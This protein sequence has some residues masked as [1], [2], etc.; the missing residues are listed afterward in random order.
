MTP[1]PAPVVEMTGITVAFPGVL[2]LDDVDLRLF[3]GEVH[4]IMG[5]NGAGKSTLVKALTGAYQLDRGEIRIDGVVQ[6]L[7]T[8][9]ES[10][11]AGIA[12]VYQDSHL[13]PNLSVAENVMLG[14][15]T[16]RRFGINWTAT[17]RRAADMLGQ[18]GLDD[19]DP[20]VRLSMLPPAIQQLVAIARA[21]VGAP[22]VLVL[23]EPTSSLEAD[24]V[25]RLFAVVRRLRDRGVAIVFISH[26]LEQVYAISDRMTVLRNGR[27]EGEYLTKRL[28]R[29]DLI[30]KMIGKDIAG[31]Q[32]LGSQ[33]Q[34]HLHEPLGG[35]VYRA[36]SLARRGQM[37]PIDL[38]LHR[39]EIVGL[40]GLRGSGRTEL[41]YLMS[42]A[43]RADSGA[44]WIDGRRS[45]IAT[46]RAGLRHRV[47][48]SSEN[49]RVE[50]VIEDLSVRDNI[51]LALQALRGWAR[52]I[53][54]EERDGLVDSYIEGL[55]IRPAAPD[56]P[57]RY[58][59][60]GAQQK[61]LLARWLATRPR[62]LILDEPTRGVD[63]AAKLDIQRRVAQLAR[64]GVAV[65]FI[66]SELEEVVRLSDRI[67]VLKDREKIGEINNGPGVTVDT[68]V[69]LIAADHEPSE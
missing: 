28:D 54:R 23:D 62:V 31:L 43:E 5:E 21:M 51:V 32:A 17:R 41:A 11:A 50:G 38:T 8:P 22:R 53:T 63:I 1:A 27:R 40:A 48:M 60:G 25:D 56:T 47:A 67:V 30:S 13:V 24:E 52:P 29:A 20:R 68:I 3:P 39:G 15:E 14:N 4:A 49:R 59:S 18:L 12:P 7:T 42:G 57:V 44:L 46:P 37:E 2:A 64:D 61:V 35:E 9:V 45:T 33:R 66:S 69:E 65:V 34:S 19:L 26:F 58:L 10:A 36:A 16:R 55:G 6:R